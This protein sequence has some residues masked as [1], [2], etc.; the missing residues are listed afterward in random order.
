[1]FARRLSGD[2]FVVLSAADVIRRRQGA[3]DISAFE[4]TPAWFRL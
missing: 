2:S 3:A 1:V 4:S